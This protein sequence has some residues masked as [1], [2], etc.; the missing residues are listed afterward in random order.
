MGLEYHCEQYKL[1]ALEPLVCAVPSL[2]S[3]IEIFGK[4]AEDEDLA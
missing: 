1:I 2:T 4:D 3:G